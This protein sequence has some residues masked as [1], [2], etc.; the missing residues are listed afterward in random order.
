[1]GA[2]EALSP[3]VRAVVDKQAWMLADA[4]GITMEEAREVVARAIKTRS[5]GGGSG[6][7]H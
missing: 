2:Y 6:T 4:R 7:G 3:L 1:M 5:S